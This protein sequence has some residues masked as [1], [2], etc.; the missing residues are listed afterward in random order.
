MLHS[1]ATQINKR[2][3]SPWVLEPHVTPSQGRRTCAAGRLTSG[4]AEE[5]EGGLVDSPMLAPPASALEVLVA[6]HCFRHTPTDISLGAACSYFTLLILHM[7]RVTSAVLSCYVARYISC[8]VLLRSTLHLLYCPD[9]H[10]RRDSQLRY[11]LY[12][13]YPAPVRIVSVLCPAQ[14]PSAAG[15]VS[16]SLKRILIPNSQ[17]KIHVDTFRSPPIFLLPVLVGSWHAE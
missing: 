6:A 10:S 16:N 9:T 13:V 11:A 15:N 12:V 5:G 14:P 8:T 3:T 17:K 2:Y 7:L 1:A 4:A